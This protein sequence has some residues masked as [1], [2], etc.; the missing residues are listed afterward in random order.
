MPTIQIHRSNEYN[1][2]MRDYQIFIDGQKAGTIANGETRDFPTTAGPHTI[3]ANV[4]WCSSPDLSVDVRENQPAIV[5]V[6][7]FRFGRILMPI[8]LVLIALH[9]ILAFLADF[10]Y[11]IF[12][13]VP[14]F[15]VQVYYLTVGRRNY[16]SISVKKE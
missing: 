16:L 5:K 8:G 13:L 2:R 3:T 10:R 7:G 6:G 11:T 9:F 15:L 4:D 12:L 14:I 1:N